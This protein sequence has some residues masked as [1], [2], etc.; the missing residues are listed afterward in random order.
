MGRA[1]WTALRT[2]SLPVRVVR[3]PSITRNCLCSDSM[4]APMLWWASSPLSPPL[5]LFLRDDDEGEW[6]PQWWLNNRRE[7]SDDLVRWCCANNNGPSAAVAGPSSMEHTWNMFLSATMPPDDASA[8]AHHPWS[9]ES[10]R[11][12][13]TRACAGRY[14]FPPYAVNAWHAS[15]EI[16]YAKATHLQK[17]VTEKKESSRHESVFSAALKW[18]TE[19]DDVNFLRWWRRSL[20]STG[21]VKT[22]SKFF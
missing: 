21:S 20:K 11:R 13:S 15:A 9:T 14:C 22:F 7:L 12:Y 1:C 19:K 4:S 5:R 6:N 8:L 16:Y 2:S 18:P 3:R 10:G 17:T